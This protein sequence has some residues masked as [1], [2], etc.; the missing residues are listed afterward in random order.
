MVLK[1]YQISCR[2]DHFI[3]FSH[4]I[5]GCDQPLPPMNG[6]V[7]NV[8]TELGGRIT[9]RCN[10]GF[11]PSQVMTAVCQTTGWSRDPALLECFPQGTTLIM[12]I[13]SISYIFALEL[14]SSRQNSH[15]AIGVIAVPVVV[16]TAVIFTITIVV[17][18]SM[19]IYVGR[20]K[21]KC[22]LFF[23]ITVKLLLVPTCF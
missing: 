18:A 16:G 23:Q 22:M 12:Y 10:D 4:S 21:R 15:V 5:P 19:R 8:T 3:L 6:S 9:F 13:H 7:D 17:V 1:T 14:N 20:A 2:S 11:L